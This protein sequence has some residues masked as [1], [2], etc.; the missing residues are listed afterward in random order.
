M[1]FRIRLALVMVS[2]SATFLFL[3]SLVL[4]YQLESILRAD[5][6]RTLVSIARAELASAFDEPE[7]EV[8]L[9][10]RSIP[11]SLGGGY[12]QVGQIWDRDRKVVYRTTNLDQDLPLEPEGF[13]HAL[14]SGQTV[15]VPFEIRGKR[16]HGLYVPVSNESKQYVAL[17]GLSREPVSEALKTIRGEFVD[18]WLEG[19][20]LVGVVSWVLA[21][22][23]TRPL[24]RIASRVEEIGALGDPSQRVEGRFGDQ[25]LRSVQNRTNE[26]LARLQSTFEQ[27]RR[28]ISDASHELRSP[29]SN[30]RCTMEVC[31]RRERSAE[32]YQSALQTCLGETIRLHRLTE[33][34]L[35]LSRADAA[36]LDLRMESFRL[37]ELAS[38][39]VEVHRAQAQGKGVELKLEE[40][41]EVTVAN[42]DRLRT[43]QILDNLLDNA[44]RFAPSGT[45]V[46]VRALGH[47]GATFL[48]V[49]DQ[50]PG[51]PPEVREKVFQRFYR[52]DESRQ[53][54]TGGAGL[55]LAIVQALAR[56]QGLSLEL[57]SRPERE[58]TLF[59]VGFPS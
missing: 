20:V 54:E 2:L 42:S 53:R 32:E 3:W 41:G 58:G 47:E 1:T 28:F 33:E 18:I 9:H 25:E 22:G 4:Y 46:T 48:E 40:T 55:G 10:D 30:L 39:S 56:A 57:E 51:L 23:L 6:E 37:S 49:E 5:L 8:H 21:V 24:Q 45:A 29:L 16:F 36:Q 44:I 50:G 7:A 26:M 35:V 52:V 34:L 59:R 38:E 19:V 14:E 43:R 27:Q 11:S 13:S 15:A 31:L 17:V 12:E